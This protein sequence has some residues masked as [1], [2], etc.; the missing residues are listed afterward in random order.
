MTLKWS[1]P[2]GNRFRNPGVRFEFARA[3]KL[4]ADLRCLKEDHPMAFETL[5]R[6]VQAEQEYCDASG[7]NAI[8]RYPECYYCSCYAGLS[9]L[10]PGRYGSPLGVISL[11]VD[12]RDTEKDESGEEPGKYPMSISF[13]LGMGGF[14]LGNLPVICR[15]EKPVKESMWNKLK[16][17]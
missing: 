8:L 7:S 16:H 9:M 5:K 12:Y 4:C 17:R 1:P 3:E 15:A 14:D 6:C 11:R 10:G 13:E 2:S